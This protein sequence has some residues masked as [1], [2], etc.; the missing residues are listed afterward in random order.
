MAN[1]GFVLDLKDGIE[2]TIGQKDS[3]IELNQSQKLRIAL[4]RALINDP[5]VLLIDDLT[6]GLD[7]QGAKQV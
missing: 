6:Q 1:A 4:A 7:P 3:V 2:T 5:K